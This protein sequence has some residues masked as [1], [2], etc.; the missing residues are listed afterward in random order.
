VHSAAGQTTL[1]EDP[2][3]SPRANDVA[4]ILGARCTGLM[5]TGGFGITLLGPPST[6]EMLV[7]GTVWWSEPS[8]AAHG[9]PICLA[10]EEPKQLLVGPELTVRASGTDPHLI[11]FTYAARPVSTTRSVADPRDSELSLVASTQ[12]QRT[13]RRATAALVT[14]IQG[15]LPGL[16]ENALGALVGVSRVTWRDWRNARRVARSAKRQKLLRLKKVLDL[17]LSVAPG[18]F[19]TTWL[20]TPLGAGLD[21]TP[22]RLFEEGREHLAAIVAARAPLPSGDEYALDAP[23]DLGGLLD[24]DR[25][26]DALAYERL[27]TRSDSNENMEG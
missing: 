20:E 17:R 4:T 5:A 3:T 6:G 22:A 27:I 12:A 10:C 21:V 14:S 18:T 23:L 15:L 19:L 26:D 13:E 1:Y 16:S 9:N 24:P 8:W 7:P 11:T 25:L 2:P